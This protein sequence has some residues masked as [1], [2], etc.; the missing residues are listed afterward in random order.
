MDTE[1]EAQKTIP[2]PARTSF[3]TASG[4]FPPW[5]ALSFSHL[6]IPSPRMCSHT[7]AY[8]LFSASRPED[9]QRRISSQMK[10]P[11]DVADDL[12]FF[13]VFFFF[14]FFFFFLILF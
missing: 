3:A 10:S 11:I 13:F 7:G 12:C 1:M 5:V 2:G 6:L 9:D 4:I 14:F 8:R